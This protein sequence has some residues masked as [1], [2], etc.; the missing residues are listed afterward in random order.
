[1]MM[2]TIDSETDP[3]LGLDKLIKDQFFHFSNMER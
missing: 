2:M 3:D 1:M